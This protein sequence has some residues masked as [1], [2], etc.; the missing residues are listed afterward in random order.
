M[1][2][3]VLAFTLI[4]SLGMLVQSMVGIAGSLLAIPLE[5]HVPDLTD[6]GDILEVQRYLAREFPDF[7]FGVS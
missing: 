7:S 3:E 4:A 6:R 2:G 1:S 5:E